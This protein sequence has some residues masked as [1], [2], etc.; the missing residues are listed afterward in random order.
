MLTGG[1]S[2]PIQTMYHVHR[3]VSVLSIITL[4]TSR[5]VVLT[6]DVCICTAICVELYQQVISLNERAIALYPEVKCLVC[7]T[8]IPLDKVR[9]DC[10]LETVNMQ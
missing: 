8:Q 1:F 7:Q 6:V 3:W 4:Y 10:A 5:R 2:Q 9:K